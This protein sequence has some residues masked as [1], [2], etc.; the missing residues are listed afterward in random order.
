MNKSD[1]KVLQVLQSYLMT[2]R[3]YVFVTVGGKRRI[4]EMIGLH[5]KTVWVRIKTGAKSYFTINRHIKKHDVRQYRMEDKA[6]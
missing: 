6:V 4:G 3:N 2:Q 5:S 1:K